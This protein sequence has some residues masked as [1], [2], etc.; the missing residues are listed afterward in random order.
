M[1]S[2]HVEVIADT[3]TMVRCGYFCS[4]CVLAPLTHATVWQVVVNKPATIP[5]HPAGPY[6]YQ[7]LVRHA[8][9]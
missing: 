9:A 3:D 8:T 5:V 6:R 2:K 1:T 4:S 7:S